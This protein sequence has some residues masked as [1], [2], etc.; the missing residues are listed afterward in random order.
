MKSAPR[1]RIQVDWSGNEVGLPAPE[2]IDRGRRHIR[3]FVMQTPWSVNRLVAL[4]ILVYSTASDWARVSPQWYQELAAELEAG[5]LFENAAFV[6]EAGY[7]QTGIG[8][9][10]WRAAENNFRG[11]FFRDAINQLD[12]LLTHYPGVVEAMGAREMLIR[13]RDLETKIASIS[14][15][16]FGPNGDRISGAKLVGQIARTEGIP[17]LY[18]WGAV[19][20][21]QLP[22][23][24]I[25]DSIRRAANELFTAYLEAVPQSLRRGEIEYFRETGELRG[26]PPVFT[27]TDEVTDVLWYKGAYVS[28]SCGNKPHV[29]TSPIELPPGRFW[30]SHRVHV[31]TRNGNTDHRVRIDPGGRLLYLTLEAT[32]HN[33]CWFIGPIARGPRSWIGVNLEVTTSN[34][35]PEGVP[36]LP[37]EE[38]PIPKVEEFAGDRIRFLSGT[39]SGAGGIRVTNTITGVSKSDLVAP[40]ASR[41]TCAAIAYYL[42][43]QVGLDVQL[44]ESDIVFREEGPVKIDVEPHRVYRRLVYLSGTSA[45]LSA[46]WRQYVSSY[47]TGGI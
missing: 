21:L 43:L 25:T 28:N 10:R 4:R 1:C 40:Y 12:S 19:M 7:T 34:L 44:R 27:P 3:F 11:G 8:H 31:T 47:S 46:L 26:F 32:E 42:A 22:P 2:V 45:G 18:F 14:K 35:P 38:L 15:E 20:A 33:Q 13:A 6:L 37:S 5:G 24:S 41:G 23:S 9:L 30:K 36:Q 16:Y 17:S 29:R 39:A